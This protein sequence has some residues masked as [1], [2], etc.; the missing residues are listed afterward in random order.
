MTEKRY[1]I[2]APIAK[3]ISDKMKLICGKG[4][5]QVEPYHLQ[6]EVHIARTPLTKLEART[7]TIK[8]IYY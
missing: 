8:K 2:F 6:K 1:E 4:T 7:K 5:C 3:Y